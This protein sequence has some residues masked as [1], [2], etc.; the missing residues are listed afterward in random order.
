MPDLIPDGISLSLPSFKAFLGVSFAV[1]LVLYI[2]ISAV[3]VFHWRRYG[4]HSRSVVLAEAVFSIVSLV[5]VTLALGA[6][7]QL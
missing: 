2:V 3:L 6:F 5:L 4:M 1:F 7:M